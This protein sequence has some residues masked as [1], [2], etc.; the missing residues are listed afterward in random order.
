MPGQSRK[1]SKKDAPPVSAVRCAMVPRSANAIS[2]LESKERFAKGFVFHWKSGM[3][4][5]ERIVVSRLILGIVDVYRDNELATTLSLIA[6]TRM[7]PALP[8]SIWPGQSPFPA[9]SF[10]YKT[11]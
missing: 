8:H 3:V 9:L 6:A 11:P 1:V 5:I 2:P 7:P 10:R 4:E